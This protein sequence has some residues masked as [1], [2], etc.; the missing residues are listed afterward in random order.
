MS[1]HVL[2]EKTETQDAVGSFE[3]FTLNKEE[4]QERNAYKLSQDYMD[5][6]PHYTPGV[7]WHPCFPGCMPDVDYPT[8]PFDTEA[9]AI[10]DARCLP[11]SEG[12]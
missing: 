3:T 12:N 1:F 6:A 11:K 2:I 8:G 10:E 7:Y 4:C 5:D 9:A